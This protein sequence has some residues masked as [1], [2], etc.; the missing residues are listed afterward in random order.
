MN[1]PDKPV[2]NYMSYSQ[3]DQKAIN[4][5]VIVLNAVSH[6]TYTK[7]K[8]EKPD[9]KM[10]NEAY[11]VQEE[12]VSCVHMGLAFH[13][14]EEEE[15]PSGTFPS[16]CHPSQVPRSYIPGLCATSANT[17]G[18]SGRRKGIRLH[19]A[20]RVYH[21]WFPREVPLGQDEDSSRRVGEG[22]AALSRFR[23]ARV[24]T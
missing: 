15:V 10:T 21:H 4:D 23:L 19:D 7:P 2:P 22:L 5:I 12:S 17:S 6:G 14:R 18:R 24:G 16:R 1:L 9:F 11:E 13:G 20:E 3:I 8:D